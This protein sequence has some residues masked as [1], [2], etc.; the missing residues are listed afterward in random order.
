MYGCGFSNN[1]N[2]PQ[3]DY[4]MKK[5]KWRKRKVGQVK[6]KI[7]ERLHAEGGDDDYTFKKIIM[8]SRSFD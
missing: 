7:G 8:S 1:F 5:Q 6:K 2:P 3:E 4:K